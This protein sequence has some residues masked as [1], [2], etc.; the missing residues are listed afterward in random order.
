MEDCD[1]SGNNG[2]EAASIGA[3]LNGLR[4]EHRY[5]I[6][7]LAQIAG[8]SASLI[9]DIEKGKVE[10][11]I[12]TL[13]RLASAMGTTI[14]FFFSEPSQTSGRVI[15]A[16]DRVM[17]HDVTPIA[18]SRAAIEAGGV[19]F[20]LAS[21][22]EAEAIEAIYGRYEVG[23]SLGDEPLVHEGEEW[24]MVLAGRL[25]VTVGSEVYFLDPGDTIWF[26]STMPHRMENVADIPT[27]YVWI[28]SPKS[29]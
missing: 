17:L 1:V 28:D 9:S 3:R 16:N 8:V 18:E 2:E 24:G 19:R 15:R 27:E 10:P 21:P 20:E 25:K 29:F 11:S 14:T 4:Q 6:R 5:S 22:K 13:K 23:A 26:P 12:S 7:R